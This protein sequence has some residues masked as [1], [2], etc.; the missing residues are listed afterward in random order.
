MASRAHITPSVEWRTLAVMLANN[1]I[2]AGI[3]V[4]HRSIP[5]VVA[6]I[7]LALCGA[8]HMSLQH[9][10]VHGHPT[11]RQW[12]NEA[13]VAVPSF[14]WLSVPAYRDSHRLH[15]HVELTRPGLDPESF[16]VDQES[17]DRAPALWRR[18]L[19]I[20]RTLLGRMLL[21][22]IVGMV[23]AI[24]L[25]LRSA[26]ASRRAAAEFAGH[27]VSVAVTVWLV[28]IVGG[29]PWWMYL[30][31]FMYGGL[32]L[33]YLRSFAEHL[34]VAEG[35]RSA[36]IRTNKA[37]ALLFLNNNLHDAHHTEPD[38]AWFRIP[39]AAERLHSDELATA[40][41]G[42]YRGY[43]EI[44]RRYLI[45]PFAQPINPLPIDPLQ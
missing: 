2:I 10:A 1:L 11:P 34:A 22:P 18:V 37:M 33:T 38:L 20:N 36:M 44:A 14:V 39:E 19:V 35:T 9:E 21:W 16:Y 8:M 3:V 32:S 17:W 30:I 29:L 31:G 6:V 25:A 13:L 40:G 7:A 27:L 41:A 23:R 15:H 45:R 42:L 26:V 28:M 5:A 12:L 43:G 24:V 4:V